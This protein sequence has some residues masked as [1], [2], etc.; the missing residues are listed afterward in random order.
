MRVL[1]R[2]LTTE[3]HGTSK[4]KGWI[5]TFFQPSDHRRILDFTKYSFEEKTLID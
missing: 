1:Q 2:L 4:D 5:A 3:K